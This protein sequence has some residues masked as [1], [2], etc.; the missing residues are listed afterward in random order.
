MGSTLRGLRLI[1]STLYKVPMSSVLIHIGQTVYKWNEI[2]III[3]II[4]YTTIHYYKFRY[5]KELLGSSVQYCN[6]FLF[7]IHSNS[8][9]S[10]RISYRM[11]FQWS[12]FTAT[13]CQLRFFI[14]LNATTIFFHSSIIECMKSSVIA[15]R[16]FSKGIQRGEYSNK[17]NAF[18]C[19]LQYFNIA[20][21]CKPF[22]ILLLVQKVRIYNQSV[23]MDP[24]HESLSK[25][26]Y[27]QKICCPNIEQTV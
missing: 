21:G 26:L 13:C 14:S 6:K 5:S 11:I 9:Y 8:N 10:K 20:A 25:Y 2:I 22:I 1:K 24:K 12:V 7:N 17:L 23:Q 19:D 15:C 27:T 16:F 4:T 18:I 3:V